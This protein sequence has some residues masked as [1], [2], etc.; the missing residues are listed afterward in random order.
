MKKVSK[1]GPK[2][3][4]EK[5]VPTK[6]FSVAKTRCVYLL[7][8]IKIWTEEPTDG[9]RVGQTNSSSQDRNCIA[10]ACTTVKRKRGE[11]KFGK[12]I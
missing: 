8:D 2:F 11:G 1:F 12:K 4:L 5:N 10:A 9:K 6:Y 7:Y 3:Q